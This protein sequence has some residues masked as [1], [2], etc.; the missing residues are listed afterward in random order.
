MAQDMAA[1][2]RTMDSTMEAREQVEELDTEHQQK[3]LQLMDYFFLS[4]N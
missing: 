4:I 3:M 1:T 2:H